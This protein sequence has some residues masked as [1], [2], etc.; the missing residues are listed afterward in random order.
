[1]THHDFTAGRLF[2]GS[3][4]TVLFLLVVG[5][6]S[7]AAAEDISLEDLSGQGPL[8]AAAAEYF[9]AFNAN[10]ADALLAFVSTYRDETSLKRT[11]PA[12]RVPR[13]QQFRGMLG[14]V[15]LRSIQASADTLLELVVFA[16]TPGGHFLFTFETSALVPLKI[17]SMGIQPTG[18]P[19]SAAAG[20]DPLA[21]A[22]TLEALV[23]AA[24]L[25]YDMPAISVAVGERGTDV[26][27][28]V[29][30]VRNL[31]TGDPVQPD[32]AFHIGSLT[33]SMT[34][35]VAARLVSRGEMAWDETLGARL[36]TL[37]MDPGYRDV[38]LTLLLQHRASVDPLLNVSGLQE[39]VWRA[40]SPEPT[41]QR[42]ALL[43]SVLDEAPATAP[44]T[45]FAYSN[46]GYI[47]AAAM[48]ER[49]T[50]ES[51]EDLV[52]AEVFAPL[53]LTTAGLGW[54]ATTDA[55]DAPRGHYYDQTGHR[56][57]PYLGYSLSGALAPAGDVHCSMGD[58]ARYGLAHLNALEGKSDWLS[59]KAA[60]VLHSPPEGTGG[61]A[62]AMG[63][64]I[65]ETEAGPTHIHAGSA[66]TFYAVICLLPET[67]RV[68]VVAMND[69]NMG[70]DAVARQII[71]QVERIRGEAQE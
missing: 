53:G 42:L 23:E 39:M 18:A 17:S 56:L 48:M 28:A 8:A 21:L 51:W 27:V 68:V 50:G 52:A 43:K 32:G 67:G 44:G 16:E 7:G 3:I 46:A 29:S 31:E 33:K 36:V 10:D 60:T 37:A 55:P 38:T 69:G 24:R 40:A 63:W 26:Q 61:P 65:E 57:Q 15:S 19:E 11:P 12:V 59:A 47:A 4:R 35:A 41:G 5:V 34:A 70:N 6:L 13:Q 9:A 20:P 25:K 66:G 45:G 71:R 64:M 14:E 30:G 49:A 22:G 2:R 54:P 62:Y 58:L 1:M